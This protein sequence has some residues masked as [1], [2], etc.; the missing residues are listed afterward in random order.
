MRDAATI[1]TELDLY[2]PGLKLAFEPG[3]W[4]WHKRKLSNDAEKRNR[5]DSKGIRLITIYDK[6]PN[7]EVPEGKDIYSFDFDLRVQKDRS[8]IQ[9]LV[10]CSGIL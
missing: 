10:K 7:D 9:S 2:V 8:G 1:G 3:A 4:F 5:S 6:A